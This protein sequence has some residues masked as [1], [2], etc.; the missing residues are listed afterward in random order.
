MGLK[1]GVCAETV[2]AGA[3]PR[4]LRLAL[5]FSQQFFHLDQLMAD[6]QTYTYHGSEFQEISFF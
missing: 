3:M 6:C 1:V 4:L 5:V 2:A